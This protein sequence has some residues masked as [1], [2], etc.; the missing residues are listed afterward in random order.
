MYPFAR[1]VSELL[2][3][4][5]AAP[6]PL[7]G[8]HVAHH[9]CWPW[10]IDMFMELNNGR[11]LTLYDLGRIV[12]FRRLGIMGAMRAQGWGGTVAGTS[13][14][15]RRRVRAFDRFELRTRLI[16]WDERFFYAEQSMWVRGECA[17]HGL[18]RL[19]LTD[20]L[21]LVPTERVAA[22][23]G[24][25]PESPPLPGWVTAWIEAEAQRPWPP[26]RETG[27]GETIAA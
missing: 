19:A 8:I 26:M 25:A 12:L 4:R 3:H 22:V 13:I 5:K 23:L 11:T 6:L 18:L 2:R 9:I 16:G 20:P 7:T 1:L 17:S 15:Y 21:G 27:D 10:D 24:A 14:R